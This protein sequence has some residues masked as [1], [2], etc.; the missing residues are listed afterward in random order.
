MSLFPAYSG[1]GPPPPDK[2][3]QGTIIP[4]T[5]IQISINILYPGTVWLNNENFLVVSDLPE[6]SGSFSKVDK[7]IPEPSQ[8]IE[9]DPVQGEECPQG[10]STLFPAYVDTKG[11]TSPTETASNGNLIIAYLTVITVTPPF[12]LAKQREL[13]RGKS[14]PRLFLVL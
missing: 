2:P 14:N 10:T 5:V 11:E 6:S 9:G 13:H 12:S 4:C 1:N 8:M 3:D 7:D